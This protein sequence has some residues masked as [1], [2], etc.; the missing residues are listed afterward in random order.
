MTLTPAALALSTAPASAVASCGEMIRTLMPL[1]TMSATWSACVVASPRPSETVT[2]MLGKSASANSGIWVVD[3]APYGIDALLQ[4]T[5]TEQSIDSG[6][7]D[8]L[9]CCWHSSPQ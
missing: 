2:F 5:P 4:E 6:A 7:A 3:L 9:S 8:S 1:A